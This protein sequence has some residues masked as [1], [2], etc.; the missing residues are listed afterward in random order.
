MS[1]KL[2]IIGRERG[3]LNAYGKKLRETP[4][5]QRGVRARRG[6]SWETKRG[7]AWEVLLELDGKATGHVCKVE[8]TLDRLDPELV[9]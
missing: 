9:E 7:V 6:I 4:L 5:S 2:T 3:L 8:I 1:E